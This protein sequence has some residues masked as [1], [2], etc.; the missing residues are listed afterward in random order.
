MFALP[1]AK[2]HWS[3]MG[4]LPLFSGLARKVVYLLLQ[5]SFKN[6]LDHVILV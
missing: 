2:P 3:L 4:E 6:T 1:K 5:V